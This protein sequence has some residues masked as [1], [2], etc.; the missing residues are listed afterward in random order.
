MSHRERMLHMVL[1]EL[2]ALVL[3]AFIG[4]LVT[5]E[6]LLPLAGLALS[7]SIIAM[8][9]NYLYNWGFDHWRKD[10]RHQRSLWLRIGHGLGFELGMILFSFPLI[11]WVLK[12]DFWSVLVLDIGAVVFFVTY[13]IIFNWLYDK[14][15]WHLLKTPQSTP[16]A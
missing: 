15:R 2:I 5:D 10:V 13:A 11:M 9:W 16:L 7:L 6:A 12:L 3:M 1:F 8:L 4:T 14:V